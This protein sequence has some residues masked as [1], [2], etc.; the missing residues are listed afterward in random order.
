ML[1]VFQVFYSSPGLACELLEPDSNEYSLQE[2]NS[3]EGI[4]KRISVSGS[5]DLVSITNT[6]GGEL[7]RNLQIRVPRRYNNPPYFKLQ[8][9]SS[10]YLLDNINFSTRGN[11]YIHERSTRR[12]NRN[13]V[14]RIDDLRA[15][16]V[17]GTQRTYLPT[18]L[19]RPANNYRFVF[20]S[21]DIVRFVE[22]GIRSSDKS[23]AAWG[24]QGAQEGQKAF[25]WSGIRNV[26]AGLYE[27]YYVAEIE[28]GNRAPER[29][30]RSIAFWHDPIWL[31]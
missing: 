5:L 24:S 7:G 30:S 4:R 16:A 1:L 31:R 15:I 9:L 25:E 22:A 2:D 27:F 18:F 17:N 12:M 29:I 28:Q 19:G 11:F 14:E 8:E 3:C 21:N 13:G 6:L 10:R 20:Y 23:Y 26:P